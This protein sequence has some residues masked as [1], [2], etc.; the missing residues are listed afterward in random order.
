M[1]IAGLI[2]AGG[3]ATRMGGVDKGLLSLNKQPMVQKIAAQLRVQ[4]DALW[5]S[6]NRNFAQY[7]AF[8]Y[9]VLVDEFE[10]TGL[11]PL[12]GIASLA[13]LLPMEYTHIQILPCDTPNL[14]NDLTAK[15]LHRLSAAQSVNPSVQAVYP[16]TAGTAHHACALVMRS[17]LAQ[18]AL[19]LTR[20]QRSL[21]HWLSLAN[22]APCDDFEAHQFINLNETHQWMMFMQAASH[23][24]SAES[25]P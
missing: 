9:P 20:G 16:K 13:A 25:M 12:S 19:C 1:K 23:Q 5:L 17:Q 8:G 3:Q 15:L 10:W 14:P 4:V 6:V 18:A 7:H 22:A 11:G 24:S 21:H 2:L